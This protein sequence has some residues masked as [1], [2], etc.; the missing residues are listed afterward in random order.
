MAVSCVRELRVFDDKARKQTL[1]ARFLA[2]AINK[3]EVELR[4]FRKESTPRADHTQ[5]GYR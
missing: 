4:A 5:M 2:G 3:E 1:Q